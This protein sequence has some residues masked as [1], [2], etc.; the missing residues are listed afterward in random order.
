MIQNMN[1][2]MA[3]VNLDPNK[4]HSISSFARQK[5]ATIKD[6]LDACK[7]GMLNHIMIDAQTFVIDDPVSEKWEGSKQDNAFKV[8]TE[9]D[10]VIFQLGSFLT[11]DNKTQVENE[12]IKFIQ[13]GKFK[14]IFNFLLIPHID[15]AG[16]AV[17]T[18]G[19]L[20]AISQNSKLQVI[21]IGANNL[22][23]FKL[24][25]IERVIDFPEDLEQAYKNLSK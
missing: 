6:V 4:M 8:I 16:I 14:F 7:L 25:K 24:A 2:N 9:N 3:N 11:L 23:N 1:S 5:N 13:S 12:L 22:T 10:I 17:L 19:A 18:R 21:N 15:S 20:H